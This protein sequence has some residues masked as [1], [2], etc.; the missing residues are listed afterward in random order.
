[1]LDKDRQ[2]GYAEY[3]KA[4]KAYYAEELLCEILIMLEQ[5]IIDTDEDCDIKAK[6]FGTELSKAA[7]KEW[8]LR[9]KDRGMEL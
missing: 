8:Y 4:K 7:K 5:S 6:A 1:M 2:I 3:T 9:H